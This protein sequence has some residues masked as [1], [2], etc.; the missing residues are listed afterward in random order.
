MATKRKLTAVAVKHHI[1]RHF[2]AG[3]AEQHLKKLAEFAIVMP[4]KRTCLS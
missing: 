4:E 1:L 2:T 3:A